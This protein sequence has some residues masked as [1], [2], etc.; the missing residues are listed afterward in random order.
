MEEAVLSLKAFGLASGKQARDSEDPPWS[1]S[2]SRQQVVVHV[3]GPLRMLEFVV[4]CTMRGCWDEMK[5]AG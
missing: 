4:R 5:L 2:T 1:P 3:L